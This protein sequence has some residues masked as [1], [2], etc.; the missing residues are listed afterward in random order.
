MLIKQ[1]ID[2]FEE[3]ERLGLGQDVLA[4]RLVEPAEGPQLLDPEGVG[5]EAAVEDQVDVERDA[6]LVPERDDRGLHVLL[7]VVTEGLE[8]PRA[9]LVR[10][11]LAGVDHEV[12]PLAYRL[13]QLA[14]VGDRLLHT[15]RG[16]RVPAAGALIAADQHL[17]RRVQEDDPHAL[18]GGAQLVEHVGQVVEVLRT[19]VAAA[20]PDH[21]GHTLDARARAGRPSRP[22][23]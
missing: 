1:V 8:D 19:R 21:Q 5:E 6:V 3:R 2:L 18:A 4:H 11:Q 20:P 13:E 15:P 17:V 22:S 14:L 9:Q 12:G 23:S 7:L 10:V 16:Q